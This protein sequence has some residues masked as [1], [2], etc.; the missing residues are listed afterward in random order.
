M[1]QKEIVISQPKWFIAKTKIQK[2]LWMEPPLINWVIEATTTSPQF[3]PLSL[4]YA[5]IGDDHNWEYLKFLLNQLNYM[6]HAMDL[7]W[8]GWGPGVLNL[9]SFQC[10]PTKF[11]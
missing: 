8:G 6:M 9:C 10:V 5:K 1:F 11:S 3:M 2:K 4:T 7:F